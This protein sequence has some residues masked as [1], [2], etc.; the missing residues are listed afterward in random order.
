MIDDEIE[1]VLAN[2]IEQALSPPGN[3]APEVVPARWV[4]SN[5][6][7]WWR[8]DG[9]AH[10]D[11]WIGDAETSLARIREKLLQDAGWDKHGEALHECIHLADALG[12]LRAALI[13][14][15]GDGSNR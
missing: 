14:K 4:A 10:L 9:E 15:L 8:K 3:L 1:R 7:R 12:S 11:E 6:I 13:G 5:F 2:W